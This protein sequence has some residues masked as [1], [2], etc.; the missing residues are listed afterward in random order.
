MRALLVPPLVIVLSNAALAQ[1]EPG[2]AAPEYPTVASALAALR[3]KGGVNASMQSGWTVIEDASTLSLWSFVPDGHPAYPAAIHRKVI[4]E[5]DN[6]AIQMNVLCEAPKPA[7]DALVAEFTK[8]NG[9][10]RE[11]LKQ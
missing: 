10:V 3:V 11:D 5:G 2:T 8:L 4:K 9:K 7:C 6:I 1:R